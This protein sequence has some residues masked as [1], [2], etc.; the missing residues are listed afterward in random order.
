MHSKLSR[1]HNNEANR[2]NIFKR[3]NAAI[4]EYREQQVEMPTKTAA[5]K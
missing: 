2:Q 1:K 5:N 3:K 4:A